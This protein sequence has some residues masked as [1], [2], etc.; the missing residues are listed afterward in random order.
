MVCT[1]AKHASNISMIS[2]A[3]AVLTPEQKL[4]WE[5]AHNQDLLEQYEEGG[6]FAQFLNPLDARTSV[7]SIV[8]QSSSSPTDN[9]A[10][11]FKTSMKGV[12]S[13]I[14]PTNLFGAKSKGRRNPI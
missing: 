14:N 2:S 10:L 12:A 7:G 1:V 3:G 8:A 4:S 6:F 11:M 13:M 9:V 5:E